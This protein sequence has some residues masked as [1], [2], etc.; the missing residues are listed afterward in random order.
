MQ[1]IR[2][3]ICEAVGRNEYKILY[4]HKTSP[5]IVLEIKERLERAGFCAGV[6][7]VVWALNGAS[8]IQ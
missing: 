2:D 3:H 8:Q 4:V 1:S 5:D 7:M 6:K